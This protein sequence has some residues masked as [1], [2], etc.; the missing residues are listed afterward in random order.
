[1]ERAYAITVEFVR[2]RSLYGAPLG[3]L[4]NTRF[5]L[6]DVATTIAVA[7]SYVDACIAAHLRGELTAVAAAQAKLWATERHGEVVD[8][9]LQLFGGAGYMNEYEIARLWRDARIQRILAGSSEVMREIIGKS[10]PLVPAAT[11]RS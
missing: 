4:Q 11:E 5:Q 10:L 9:C 1:M 2:Q 8:S 7:R 6:A 3:A